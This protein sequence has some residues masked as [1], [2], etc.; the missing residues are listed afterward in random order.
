MSP[1]QIRQAAL[2]MLAFVPAVGRNNPACMPSM[3]GYPPEP[4]EDCHLAWMCMQ[5]VQWADKAHPHLS[6]NPA[7]LLG[8][9]NRWL[10]FVQGVTYARGRATITGMRTI[11]R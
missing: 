3:D 1:E 10:G 8:K 5:I 6:A 2:D 9:A 4:I 11:N 7:E